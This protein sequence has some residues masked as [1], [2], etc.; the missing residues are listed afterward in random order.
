[1][2]HFMAL[3][4]GA[5][6][7][8]LPP[9]ALMIVFNS[10][11]R[12]QINLGW[13]NG[14]GGRRIVVARQGTIGTAIDAPV[15]GAIYTANGLYGTLAA[16]LGNSYIVYDGAGNTATVTGLIRNTSYKFKVYEYTGSGSTAVYQKDDTTD[17][18]NARLTSL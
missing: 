10:W 4:H 1:M 11:S 8:V 3:T 14:S 18:P 17:N 5:T 15:N 13:T 7:G 2:G 12:T 6:D 9:Q 16:K